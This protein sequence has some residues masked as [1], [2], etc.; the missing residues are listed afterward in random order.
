LVH[1]TRF[2]AGSLRVFRKIG[3]RKIYW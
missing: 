2:R 1:S 3:P